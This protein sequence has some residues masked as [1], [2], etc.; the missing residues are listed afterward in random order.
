[1]VTR[2]FGRADKRP[3][4]Q[5]TGARRGVSADVDRRARRYLVS[6]GVRTVCFVL[7]VLLHGWLRWVMIGAALVLPY[8][9]VVFANSGRERIESMPLT[10]RPDDTRSIKGPED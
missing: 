6:M 2:P 4:Y 10:T 1:M 9:S 3:V 7:A 5:I 8:L